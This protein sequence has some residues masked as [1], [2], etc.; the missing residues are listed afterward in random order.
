MI[1]RSGSNYPFLEL[2]SMILKMFEP[3][4][5]YCMIKKLV[6]LIYLLHE[7][8]YFAISQVLWTKL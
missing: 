5:L 1:N 4:R 8:Q 6:D 2:I 3:L 7:N